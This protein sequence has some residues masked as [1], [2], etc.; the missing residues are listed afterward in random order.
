LT[1]EQRLVMSRNARQTAEQR[2][3]EQLVI[4]AYLRELSALEAGRQE[5]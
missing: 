2:F 4:D 5:C 3:D 1:R